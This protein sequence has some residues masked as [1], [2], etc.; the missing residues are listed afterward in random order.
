MLNPFFTFHHHGGDPI[1]TV[2]ENFFGQPPNT[3]ILP[4]QAGGVAPVELFRFNPLI[5]NHIIIDFIITNRNIEALTNPFGGQAYRGYKSKL[6]RLSLISSST[7]FLGDFNSDPSN[8]QTS[9]F[10]LENSSIST[11]LVNNVVILDSDPEQE[12][13]L[14][15]PNST[16]TF[17]MIYDTSTQ[18]TKFQVRV[19]QQ[20]SIKG[21]A[22]LM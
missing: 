9:Y 3:N 5:Y 18:M 21:I 11:Q 17:Y 22:K 19:V 8:G 2:N 20:T 10:A 15:I 6:R 12:V 4:D 7:P 1:V 16:P 14:S 13:P